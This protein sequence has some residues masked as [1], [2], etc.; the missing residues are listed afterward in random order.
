MPSPAGTRSGARY[1]KHSGYT[2]S[3]ARC[4]QIREKR[5]FRFALPA[6][7]KELKAN[8]PSIFA[9]HSEAFEQM[10]SIHGVSDVLY[11][12]TLRVG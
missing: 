11:Q 5:T 4:F 3:F 12:N 7:Y 8:H 2:G 9:R 10:R 6:D 1:K